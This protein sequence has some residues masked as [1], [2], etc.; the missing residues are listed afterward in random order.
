MVVFS[1]RS[2]LISSMEAI[3]IPF[4]FLLSILLGLEGPSEVLETEVP[5]CLIALVLL[6]RPLNENDLS[7]FI[8]FIASCRFLQKFK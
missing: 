6:C 8:M 5:L 3:A 1:R 7:L 4:T 2:N